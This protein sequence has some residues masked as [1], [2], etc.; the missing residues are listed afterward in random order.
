M[1][2]PQDPEAAE[3]AKTTSVPAVDLPRLVRL[4]PCPFCGSPAKTYHDSV[5]CSNGECK[6]HF[7]AAPDMHTP[8]EWNERWGCDECVAYKAANEQLRDD[9]RKMDLRIKQLLTHRGHVAAEAVMDKM[10]VEYP[11]QNVK[12]H[13]PGASEKRLK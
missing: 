6:M 1:D 7:A 9:L 10:A 8:E 2:K 3:T 11:L 4:L 13:S 5:T 12:E